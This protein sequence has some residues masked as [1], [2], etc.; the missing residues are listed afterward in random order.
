VGDQ[1]KIGAVS[2]DVERLILKRTDIRD[3]EGL[4]FLV[5]NGEVRIVANESRETGEGIH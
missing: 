1:V 4:V 2:G 3:A 5:P